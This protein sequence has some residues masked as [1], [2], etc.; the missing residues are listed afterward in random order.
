[1]TA[2][3][4]L[5]AALQGAVEWTFADATL[6]QAG[7]MTRDAVGG[8]SAA[9]IETAC[10]AKLD[11]KTHIF[12]DHGPLLV[13]RILIL[14]GSLSV[15]PAPGNSVVIDAKTYRLGPVRRDGIASHWVCEVVADGA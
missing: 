2:L 6:R 3:A 14:A 1:M 9:T 4:G 8:Y 10:K 5:S 11:Q 7:A 15:E 13:T 12:P